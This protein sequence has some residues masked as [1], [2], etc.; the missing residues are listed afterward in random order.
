MLLVSW[1]YYD[2]YFPLTLV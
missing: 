1:P 2:N